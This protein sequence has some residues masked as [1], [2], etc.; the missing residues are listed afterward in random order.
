VSAG[1]LSV[2]ADNFEK[3]M[4]IHA[5]RRIPKA[6]WINDRDQFLQPKQELSEEFVNDCTIWNV[7][8]NSNQTA[9]MKDV[10]YEKEIYQ[11]KNNFFP[12]LIAELKN[13]EITDSDFSLALASAEDRFVAKWLSEKEFSKEAKETIEAGKEIYKFY[14][15][16]LNQLRTNLFEI[17]TW[18]AGLWQIKKVLQDQDLARDLFKKLKEKHDILRDKIL[19]QIYD[20]EFIPKIEI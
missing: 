15:A 3:S 12:F 13:W 9:S 14:F 2:T 6:T 7:F 16:N 17:K 19:P 5:V 20:Y 11:I 4:V 8:S 10:E 18:D 1:A